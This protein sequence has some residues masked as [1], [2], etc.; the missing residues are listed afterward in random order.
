[1][2]LECKIFFVAAFL[3]FQFA[4][5][6]KVD[7]SEIDSELAIIAAEQD[8]S[9]EEFFTPAQATENISDNDKK[10]ITEEKPTENSKPVEEIVEVKEEIVNPSYV[11]EKNQTEEIS[12]PVEEKIQTE[13][14]SK[15]VEEKIQTE[16][17]S[18]PV[19]EKIQTEEI[20]KPVEEKIQTE[21]I[22]K[23][24]EEKIQTEEKSPSAE[25]LQVAEMQNT[26]VNY[27]NFEE[28]AKAVNF[29]PL[30]IP[31]KSGYS[32]TEIFSVANQ[33]AEIRYNRRWEPQVSLQIRTYKRKANEEL[34]DISGVRGVKWRIDM[35]S[36]SAVYI[37][38]IN[39]TSHAAAWSSGNYTFSAYVE[40][41]SF[42]A[43][44]SL[45]IDELVDLTTHYYAN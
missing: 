13:E 22:S 32:M 5:F 38:K 37:A 35:T 34:K 4:N 29:T 15:P 33:I 11:E 20:S 2:K 9:G 36:G 17:I 30:Y 6:G 43:F 10:K 28:L 7:A 24:V 16:E 3:T 18:K 19:E 45:V 1:M 27:A 25:N 23:P 26:V 8:N 39:E 21:E 44:H 41:L 40:N 12:K 31:K 42:A 14:I